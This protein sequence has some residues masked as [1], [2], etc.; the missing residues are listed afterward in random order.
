MRLEDVAEVRTQFPKADFWLQRKGSDLKVGQPVQDYNRENIGIRVERRDLFEPKFLFYWLEHLWNQ[1]YWGSIA[2]GALKLK[3][4]RVAD[5]QKLRLPWELPEPESYVPWQVDGQKTV[6]G[7]REY[8]EIREHLE[9]V[10]VRLDPLE[11]DL[12]CDP[13]DDPYWPA[14]ENENGILAYMQSFPDWAQWVCALTMVEMVLPIWN[15]STLLWQEIDMPAMV[16]TA[17]WLA[18]ESAQ[19][20]FF[21]Q[22]NVRWGKT[23]KVEEV[24][25][26]AVGRTEEALRY[27][28]R[29]RDSL[30]ETLTTRHESLLYWEGRALEHVGSAIVNLGLSAAP[31]FGMDRAEFERA[32]RLTFHHAI[33]GR[34]IAISHLSELSTNW[35]ELS[36]S[37]IR[38]EQQK[39]FFKE[40]W[41]RCRCRL[42]F[43]F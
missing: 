33:I 17:P 5:V 31:D 16:K 13:P 42:A 41:K 3:H 36:T 18:V 43:I 22:P 37:A 6:N 25:D 29:W 27:L 14:P 21:E 7:A 8:E 23:V 4:I 10:P 2:S 20:W 24:Y 19:N 38:Q 35:P 32:I 9:G 39:N 1:G 30:P 12:H 26:L 11:A 34:Y 28:E 40:W 15:E